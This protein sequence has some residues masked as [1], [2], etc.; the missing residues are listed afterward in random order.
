MTG[1]CILE[2]TWLDILGRR[3]RTLN[4]R[5][6]SSSLGGVTHSVLGT[7]GYADFR[8]ASLESGHS[9]SAHADSLSEDAM[10]KAVRTAPTLD[11]DDFLLLADRFSLS[12]LAANKSPQ[13]V[14][15]Y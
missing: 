8:R 5:V 1:C 11:F 9:A 3:L 12:L 15:S 10:A 2:E 14:R 6:P 13:T 4:Q 7:E